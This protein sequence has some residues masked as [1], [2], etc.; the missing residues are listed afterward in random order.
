MNKTNKH[1]C[2][3]CKKSFSR[4]STLKIH[5]EKKIC[6]NYK[7]NKNINN[8]LINKNDI[9]KHTKLECIIYNKVNIINVIKINDLK[10]FKAKD[11]ALALYYLNSSYESS[12]N[13]INNNN[14]YKI[15]NLNLNDMICKSNALY[16][17]EKGIKEL[18]KNTKSS[19]KDELL[20]WLK[21]IDNK[22][23]PIK[24]N[25]IKTN[26]QFYY[27]SELQ[28]I[29]N[30]TQNVNNPLNNIKIAKIIGF[31]EE[32]LKILK[33]FWTPCFNDNWF[34]ISDDIIKNYL[35]YN[36]DNKNCISNFNNRILLKFGEKN[37]DFK[38]VNSQHKLV[39]S[40]S[41]YMMSKIFKHGG[42]N[43]KYYIITGD[44]F[45]R[46][47]M[48]CK[49][50]KGNQIRKYYIKIEKLVQ[51]YT[52]YIYEINK[53]Q[54]N[55]KI[56][57]L[58]NKLNCYQKE[59]TYLKKL[60]SK[61]EYIYIISSK[62]YAEQGLYKIGRT[63]NIKGRLSTLN[64]SHTIKDR[65][66][67][68]KKFKVYDSKIAEVRIK[69]ILNKIRDHKNREFY[70][71]I[72]CYLE[73]IVDL[74]CKNLDE[75]CKEIND[76]IDM[77]IDLNNGSYSDLYVWTKGIEDMSIFNLEKTLI[78]QDKES[79]EIKIVENLSDENI[80]EI[81]FKILQK[82][83]GFKR[84]NSFEEALTKINKYKYIKND[85]LLNFNFKGEL[86]NLI[87]NYIKNHTKLRFKD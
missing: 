84:I 21:N 11:V 38:L 78:T 52:K 17:N 7:I 64:T 4:N 57:N 85:E 35:G 81:I 67:I 26:S 46:I 24:K 39:K 40:C 65:M 37:I 22:V 2:N 30:K 77:L 58:K 20:N 36:K 80:E 16:I 66:I 53:Q 69:Y 70:R 1:I 25:I 56:N 44:F 49:T 76:V 59:L 34:Y 12:F 27:N 73:K 6:Q 87:I 33:L 60:E 82:K 42:S 86:K 83:K 61:Q 19:F 32:E 3:L 51:L 45:K 54:Q 48:I 14:K 43:K 13:L 47:S 9:I 8:L 41:S 72:Y 55:I 31:S 28:L 50:T 79:K 15:S 10:L 63:K 74:I 62:I 71:A 29:I 75:E 68:I 23:I 18:C 5:K